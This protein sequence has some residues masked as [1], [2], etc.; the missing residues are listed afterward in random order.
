MKGPADLDGLFNADL[1]KVLKA[2]CESSDT[3]ERCAWATVTECLIPLDKRK[4]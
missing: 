2:D 3:Y 1:A 4:A